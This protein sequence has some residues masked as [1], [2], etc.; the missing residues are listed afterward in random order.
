MTLPFDTAGVDVA[1]TLATIAGLA[2]L[3]GFLGVHRVR[4][5]EVDLVGRFGLRRGGPHGRIDRRPS[6]GRRLEVLLVRSSLAAALQR[7]LARAGLRFTVTEY[8]LA[9]VAGMGA[10]AL[11]GALLGGAPLGLGLAAVGLYAPRLMVAYAH[12]RRLAAFGEQLAETLTLMS[13]SLRAG[14]SLL[15]AMETVAREAPEPT[16]D[17]I[18]RVV[19]EVG[20]GLSPEAALRNLHGRIP[21]AEL[22][23]MVTAIGVQHEVGGN[24]AKMFDSLCETIRERTRIAG[25]IQTLTAQQRL[26]GYVITLLPIAI[27]VGLYVMVPDYLQPL[28]SSETVVCVP[29]FAIPIA[30]GVMMVAGFIAM[31]RIVEIEV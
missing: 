23:L 31:R 15:Q 4:S 11:V 16:A 10:G 25:E 26:G 27:G 19:G 14:Q 30:A 21:S 5:R 17:E 29:A 2:S 1:L 9:H 12:R 20:L 7:D 28:F 6:I 3:L 22:D 13:S 24:L 8:L 18:G